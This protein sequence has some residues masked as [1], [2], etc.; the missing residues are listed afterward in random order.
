MTNE[1]LIARG[2]TGLPATDRM[3]RYSITGLVFYKD[4][5]LVE[6]EQ[7]ADHAPLSVG[8]WL[9]EGSESHLTGIAPPRRLYDYAVAENEQHNLHS[10][11]ECECGPYW[12]DDGHTLHHRS[13][14]RRLKDWWCGTAPER[15]TWEN[16]P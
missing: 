3:R 2:L 1:E 9:V 8:H 11:L 16:R 15:A 5:V 10:H 12:S 7:G 14:I 13:R 6:T 4:H